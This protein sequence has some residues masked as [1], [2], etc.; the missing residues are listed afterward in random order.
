VVQSAMNRRRPRQAIT[1]QHRRDG[2]AGESRGDA[3]QQV[4]AIGLS[5]RLTPRKGTHGS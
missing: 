5:H 2:H 1:G 3:F 4:S